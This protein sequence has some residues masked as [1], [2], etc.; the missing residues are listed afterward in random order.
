MGKTAYAETKRVTD[1][2]KYSNQLCKGK[3]PTSL[4]YSGYHYYLPWVQHQEEH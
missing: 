3:L 4:C 2:M 1:L